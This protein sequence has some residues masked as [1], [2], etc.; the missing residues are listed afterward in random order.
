[1]KKTIVMAAL[2]LAASAVSS[3]GQGSVIFSSY[4][5]NGTAGVA[6]YLGLAGSSTTIPSSFHADLYAF[7]G[8]VSDPVNTSLAT[9]PGSI[10]AIPLGLTDLNVTGVTYNQSYAGLNYF[11]SGVVTTP[12]PTGAGITFEVV[13]FNGSTY[14]NSTIRGR[15]G[16]FTMASLN[17]APAPLNHLGDNGQPFPVMYVTSVPEPTTL[18]LAGLGGLASLI[19]L[20]RKQ[21]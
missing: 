8:A 9:G 5:A 12:T 4:S 16:S 14:A 11:N 7:A 2:G 21:A 17:A 1:M 15:S 10:T 6:T 3:F 20:R 13:A 18:A 19:A